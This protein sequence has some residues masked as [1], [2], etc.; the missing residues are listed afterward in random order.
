MKTNQQ[1]ALLMILFVLITSACRQKSPEKLPKYKDKFRASIASFESQKKKTDARVENGVKRL[2]TIQDALANAKDVDKEF[3]K[4]YGQWGKVDNQVKKLNKDYENLKE[5]ANN[6]FNAMQKQTESL[7]DQKTKGELM[8][9]LNKTRG[10]Y[11]E[12]LQK[13]SLAIEKLRALHDEAKDVIKALEVAVSLGQIAEIS[14]G[15]KSIEDR[16][17]SIMEEL[18]QTIAE[19]KDLYDQKINTF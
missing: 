7:N 15:L 17:G 16:V 11:D 1:F 14:S 6:L 8:A 9:A 12:T 10:S 5:D 2:S 18:N 4:V 3:A 19:S 13:T